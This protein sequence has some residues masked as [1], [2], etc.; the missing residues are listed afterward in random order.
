MTY[1]YRMS[2]HGHAEKG[3]D[4]LLGAVKAQE[5]FDQGAFARAIGA[6]QSDGACSNGERHI[7]KCGQIAITDADICQFNYRRQ[8]A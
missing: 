5:S 3:H 4:A 2:R 1:F 6:E 7:I 8:K